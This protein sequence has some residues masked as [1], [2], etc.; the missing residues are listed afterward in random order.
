MFMS[1]FV[2]LSKGEEV[3]QGKVKSDTV[4]GTSGKCCRVDPVENSRTNCFVSNSSG[5]RQS[6]VIGRGICSCGS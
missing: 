6:P 4:L 5:H 3:L 2:L 1:S